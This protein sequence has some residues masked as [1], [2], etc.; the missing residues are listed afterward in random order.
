MQW[1]ALKFINHTRIP[2]LKY[3]MVYRLSREEKFSNLKFTING[4]IETY[5]Q[6]AHHLSSGVDGVMLGR[7]AT[8]GSCVDLPW[9]MCTHMSAPKQIP[10]CSLKWMLDSLARRTLVCQGMR[11]W[12]D[13]VTMLINAC[14]STSTAAPFNRHSS[15]SQALSIPPSSSRWS[16][17]GL[18]V[19]IVP[20]FYGKKEGRKF[21]QELNRELDEDKRKCP[22]H[23]RENWDVSA[24][25]LVEEA[26]RC[27]S[28]NAL[29]ER[30]PTHDCF[31]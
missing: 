5:D 4:G 9:Y 13:I 11:C 3:D 8:K 22:K 12:R 27:V 6:I 1:D 18:L 26:L 16:K 25:D 28:E 14:K 30:P 19:P 24:W 7:I 2:P 20:L 29:H 31:D 21:R 17:R 23:Q 15:F 10:G